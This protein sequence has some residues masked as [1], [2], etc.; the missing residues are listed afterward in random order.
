MAGLGCVDQLVNPHRYADQVL[1]YIS[2]NAD[3]DKSGV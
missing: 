1:S 2:K 3:D